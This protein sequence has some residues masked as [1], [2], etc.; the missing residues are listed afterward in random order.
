MAARSN[1]QSSV[2]AA[3]AAGRGAT[4]LAALL[5]LGACSTDSEYDA[6]LR[7]NTI[8]AY[9]DYLRLHPD[10]VHAAEARVHLAELVESR[11][12]QRAHA[13]DTGEAYQQ[14][15]RSYPSGRHAHDALIAITDLNLAKLPSTEASSPRSSALRAQ[16]AAGPAPA[17][18][19]APEPA[20][21]AVKGAIARA[22]DAAPVAGGAPP[23]AVASTKPA[24]K[25]LPTPAARAAAPA[26]VAASRAPAKVAPPPVAAAPGAVIQ[27]GA[28]ATEA[29]AKA[30][31][32]HLAERYPELAGRTPSISAA[33]AADG[34]ELHRLQVGGFSRESAEAM[35][36]ALAAARDACL[37][38]PART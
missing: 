19:P 6:A 15:L 11:E 13:A 20:T 36:R 1:E 14:Y 30:A 28:F 8:S 31:W 33:H 32:K 34:H 23:K 21:P 26:V 18:A 9:D 7:T 38:I 27:L 4:V 16:A 29:S 22:P 2:L 17:P 3:R 25:A 35:C 12:W 10:G 5:A 24:P 37:L